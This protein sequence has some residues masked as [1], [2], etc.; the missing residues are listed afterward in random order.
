MS[1]P[2]ML[3]GRCECAD[4]FYIDI[5]PDEGEDLYSIDAPPFNSDE[6]AG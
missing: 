3:H 1:G 5:G 2:C 6:V 4:C